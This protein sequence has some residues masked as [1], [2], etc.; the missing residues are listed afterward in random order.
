VTDRPPEPVRAPRRHGVG[1]STLA[2]RSSK[3]VLSLV[4]IGVLDLTWYGW[5]FV[6][7]ASE[8]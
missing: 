1:V 7:A 6:T 8:A 4:S 5:Q 3:V 2:R